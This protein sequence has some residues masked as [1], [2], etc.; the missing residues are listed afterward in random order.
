MSGFWNFRYI[1]GGLAVLVVLAVTAVDADARRGGSF[2]SRGSRTYTAPPATQTAPNAAPINRSITQPQ[3][4]RAGSV[5][6]GTAPRAGGLFNRGG[7]MGGLM[8]G[9]LGAGLLG[10]LFGG[11][12]LSGLSSFAGVLGLLIQIVLVVVVARLLWAWW[13]RRQQPG[14]A[15]AGGPSLRDA[16][17]YERPNAPQPAY[18]GGGSAA[19]TLG[20]GDAIEL[21]PQDFDVFE[22]RLSDVLAA[23]S[24]EDVVK[25]RAFATPEVVSYLAEELNDNASRGLVNTVSDV[26]LQQGDLAEAWREGGTEYATVAMRYSSVDYTTQRATGQLVDGSKEPVERT[27]LWTFMRSHGG[28]WILSAIQEA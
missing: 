26:K 7:F 22:K 20:G 19:P 13:Q 18:G 14:Y 5:G 11:G 12:F 6:Q 1:L 23:F 4:P 2:G 10:L 24:N 3:T 8:A 15:T 9:F 21:T 17:P 16:N 28:D 25:L 27:E